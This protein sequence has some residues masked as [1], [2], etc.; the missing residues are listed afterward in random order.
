[1]GPIK[2]EGANMFRHALTKIRASWIQTCRTTLRMNVMPSANLRST[3]G[4]VPKPQHFTPEGLIPRDV[5]INGVGIGKIHDLAV[6]RISIVMRAATAPPRECPVRA[7]M[8]PC[9]MH[10]FI[11]SGNYF[12]RYYLIEQICSLA[13]FELRL[14]WWERPPMYQ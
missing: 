10:A 2:N 9:W 5:V 7:S 14:K 4:A 13:Q 8:Y 11:S 3:Q 12:Q 6:S 1:M